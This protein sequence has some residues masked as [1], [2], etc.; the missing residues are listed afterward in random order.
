MSDIRRSRDWR[1]VTGGAVVFAV[2]GVILLR[3]HAQEFRAERFTAYEQRLDAVQRLQVRL[4][5][6]SEFEMSAVQAVTDEESARFAAQARTAMGALEQERD[7]LAQHLGTHATRDEQ[8]TLATFSKALADYHRLDDELL[9]LSVRNTNLKA[10]QLAFGPAATAVRDLD[11]A[12]SRIITRAAGAETRD[13]RRI[14]LLAAGA[15][16]AALRI[17]ALLPRHIAEQTDAG[18]D[19][20]ESD[21]DACRQ[22][23]GDNLSTLSGLPAMAG[24]PD[25][26]AALAAFAT[27]RDLVPDIVALSRQNTNVKSLTL[28]LNQRRRLVLG[29]QQALA[30]LEL[31]VRREPLPLS[32]VYPR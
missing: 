22:V 32:P 21:L 30:D 28:S 18:M 17:Q 8:A 13:G 12:L 15:E 6:T 5:T 11:D 3:Y 2:I 1:W 16:R 24:T 20:M 29:C 26:E 9:D 31:A 27:Y 10:A 19:D 23:V 4:A 7:Q 25:L 14:M